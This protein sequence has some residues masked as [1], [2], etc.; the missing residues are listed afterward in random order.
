MKVTD[1][2][3]AKVAEHVEPQLIPVGL[4][5]TVPE[6]TFV[7]TTLNVVGV[8][9]GVGEGVGVG[10]GPGAGKS[11]A[12]PLKVPYDRVESGGAAVVPR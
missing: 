8:G 10:A 11:L 5:V 7:T 12:T 6:P 3:L 4:V 9:V 1:V 2:P